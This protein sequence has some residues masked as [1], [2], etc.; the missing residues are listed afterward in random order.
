MDLR[1]FFIIDMLQNTSCC[2]I[3]VLGPSGCRQPPHCAKIVCCNHSP[4]TARIWPMVCIPRIRFFFIDIFKFLL[5]SGLY[6]DGVCEWSAGPW[7]KQSCLRELF[8][9]HAAHFTNALHTAD[10]VFLHRHIIIPPMVELGKSEIKPVHIPTMLIYKIQHLF[11]R[12]TYFHFS[13]LQQLCVVCY[14][15]LL[16]VMGLVVIVIRSDQRESDSFRVPPSH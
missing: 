7:C 10:Q 2:K 5:K 13:Y 16:P 9:D 3:V 6:W 12:H 11:M 1:R 8:A 4:M 15:Y 14:L